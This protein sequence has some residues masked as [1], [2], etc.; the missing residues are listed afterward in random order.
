MKALVELTPNTSGLA[1]FKSGDKGIIEGFLNGIPIV[2]NL[3]TKEI[4]PVALG[5]CRVI[6]WV[7]KDEANKMLGAE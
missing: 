2:V 5:T 4:Q 6:G 7:D 3:R 1:G